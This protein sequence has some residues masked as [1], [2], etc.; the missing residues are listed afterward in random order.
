MAEGQKDGGG[1]GLDPADHVGDDVQRGVV[2]PVHVL[3]H[4]Q[5]GGQPFQFGDQG[6]EDV[7]GPAGE[8]RFL[9]RA[10]DPGR[11]I[12]QGYRAVGR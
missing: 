4:Q 6:A 10:A 11:R 2:G 9:Q 12:P 5:H 3:D 1:Q 8:Q 7:L